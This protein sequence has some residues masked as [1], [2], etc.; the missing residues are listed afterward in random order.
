MSE[1]EKLAL[2]FLPG[3]S[4]KE[5]ISDLSGRGVGADAVKTIVES[6]GGR[7]TVNSRQGHGTTVLLELPVSV[8]LSS[9]FHVRMNTQ[10]YAVNME[11]IV[12]TEKVLKKDIQT[13]QH[14]PVIH[15]RGEVIP[16]VIYP[17]LL[18][19]DHLNEQESILIL[20]TEEGKV[21]F[22]VDEFVGQLDVVQ[23]PLT[24]PLAQHPLISGVAL[25]GDD[26][27]LFVLNLQSL[28]TKNK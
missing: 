4:T 5:E 8:A 12:E 20:Q 19:R 23:K 25:L 27:P 21:G 7:V 2:I 6:L 17:A 16:L 9:V 10:N 3:L 13:V 24:G 18:R 26:A 14:Q 15:L 11:D 28:F 1:E 22:V